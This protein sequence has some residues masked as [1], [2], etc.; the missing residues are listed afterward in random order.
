MFDQNICDENFLVRTCLRGNYFASIK[1]FRPKKFP[2]KCLV[3][4]YFRG[5]D[6]ATIKIF[7][8][9][10][11]FMKIFGSNL[12][13]RKWFCHHK[14]FYTIIFSWKFLVEICFRGNN[15]AIIK[16]FDQKVLMKFFGRNRF[17]RKWFCD[18]KNFST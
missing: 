13:S 9:T 17:S 12:F 6:F 18:H 4:I 10:N 2:W 15:F 5:N 11:F 8:P 16:I 1:K 7:R 14:K 3:R